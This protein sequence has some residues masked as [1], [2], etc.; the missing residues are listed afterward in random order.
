MNMGVLQ[1]NLD[2]DL[3]DQQPGAPEPA[4]FA[5]IA[6]DGLRA[7]SDASGA[8]PIQ[9]CDGPLRYTPALLLCNP[10]SDCDHQLTGRTGSAE[11][12]FRIADKLDTFGQ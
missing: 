2:G 6:H 10:G 9:A 3:P 8:N 1:A 4:D 12:S 7:E 5:N 11:V